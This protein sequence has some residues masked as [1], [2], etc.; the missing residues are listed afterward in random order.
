MLETIMEIMFYRKTGDIYNEW[1][2]YDGHKTMRPAFNFG[3]SLFSGSILDG[4]VDFYLFEKK[5]IVMV[6]FRTIDSQELYKMVKENLCIGKK[7][8]I[9]IGSKVIGEAILLE[10]CFSTG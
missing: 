9:Q 3:G 8:N 5:Y 6:D 1:I 7:L 4:G 10:Y 2:G